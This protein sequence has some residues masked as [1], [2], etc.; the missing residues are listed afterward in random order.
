MS[1]ESPPGQHSSRRLCMHLCVAELRP[2]RHRSGSKLPGVARGSGRLNKRARVLQLD[3]V[4]PQSIFAVCSCP[5]PSRPSADAESTSERRHGVE[6]RTRTP[7][8]LAVW[9]DEEDKPSSCK[10]RATTTVL[11]VRTPSTV[12]CLDSF[13]SW[14][15][16]SS[17]LLPRWATLPVIAIFGKAS[18]PVVQPL[19]SCQS[20]P[21]DLACNSRRV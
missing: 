12:R 4:A 19:P 2:S 14:R 5:P 3:S 20:L 11:C 16:R 7:S 6:G 18:Q 17:P 1:R 13:A 10:P 9:R 15:L 21:A 8:S